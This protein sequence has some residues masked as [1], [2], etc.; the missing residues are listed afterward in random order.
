MACPQQADATITA[1]GTGEGRLYKDAEN[2]AQAALDSDFGNQTLAWQKA[3]AC[4]VGC[5]FIDYWTDLPV[6]TPPAAADGQPKPL[7]KYGYNLGYS[8][9]LKETAAIHRT[10]YE[11]EEDQAAGK[12]KRETDAKKAKEEAAK[13]AKKAAETPPPPH[14]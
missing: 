3:N 14:H 9:T 5:S 7:K 6:V 4:P 8:V 11:K 2:L 12:L 1:T 10:C 13:A